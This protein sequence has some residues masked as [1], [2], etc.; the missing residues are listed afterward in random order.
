MKKAPLFVLL[1]AFLF[2]APAAFSEDKGFSVQADVRWAE[3]TCAVAVSRDLDPAIQAL[4]RAKSDAEAAIDA[5]FSGLLFRALSP[6]VVDSSR[7]VGDLLKGD[8]AYFSWMLDLARGAMKDELVLSQDFTKVTARY[9]FPLMGDRGIATPLLTSRDAPIRK[10]LGYVSSRVFSG[11]VIYA[12]DKVPAVGLAGEQAP[13]PAL[14]PRLFDEEMS[15]V[16]DKSMCRPAALAERGMV[17]YAESIDEEAILK[18][19]GQHPLRIAARAVFGANR[20]D[21][22]IPTEAARRILS[23]AENIE[24]LKE[25]RI[26]VIYQSLK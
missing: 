17:G 22:V 13:A 1:G 9:N 3:G 10:R 6:I 23:V 12:G 11:L 7:T 14:F 2:R 15:L 4:P 20:C 24:I 26:L 19:A 5:A 25:G 21:I 18:R 8:P 16:L